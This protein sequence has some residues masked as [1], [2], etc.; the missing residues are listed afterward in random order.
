M[1]HKADDMETVV[2]TELMHIESSS[3]GWIEKA[4]GKSAS[5]HWSPAL[6]KRRQKAITGMRSLTQTRHPM[7][8]L[9]S[10]L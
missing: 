3:H 8:L 1:P 4:A 6:F 5:D 9:F 2:S 7:Q 10:Y